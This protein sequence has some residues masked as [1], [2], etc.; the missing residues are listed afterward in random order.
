MLHLSSLNQIPRTRW[1]NARG[2][3]QELAM[4]RQ[5]TSRSSSHTERRL[6]SLNFNDGATIINFDWRV[7]LAQIDRDSPFSLF[8]GVDRTL[9]YI[10][11]QGFRLYSLKTSEE[12]RAGLDVI[13]DKPLTNINFPGELSLYA[14]LIPNSKGMINQEISTDFNIMVR[15]ETRQLGGLQIL[16][17]D[18]DSGDTTILLP[19]T[20]LP[21]ASEGIIWAVD[22]EW[23]IKSK[24]LTLDLTGRKND[25]PS[26]HHQ[27]VLQGEGANVHIPPAKFNGVWWAEEQH[28][29]K[30]R[31]LTT[32]A[33]LIVAWFILK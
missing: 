29:W 33:S 8:P 22:G 6:S 7:S 2:F 16:Q 23:S 28:A 18:P 13:L 1:K 12:A 9:I 26:P 3:T 5:P 19:T 21:F 30:L 14:K 10:R 17:S 32:G 31:P 24:S 27:A 25:T 4:Y 11:G 20:Q 15:R